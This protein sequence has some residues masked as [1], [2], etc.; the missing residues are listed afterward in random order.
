MTFEEWIKVAPLLSFVTAIA[1]AIT[2]LSVFI[3][4]RRANRRRATLDM[5]MKSLHDT[6]ARNVYAEFKKYIQKDKDD[7]DTFKLRSLADQSSPLVTERSAVIAQINIYEL[8]A[9]GINRGVFDEHFY[10][11][12]FHG[13]FTKDYTSALPML[14]A[15]WEKRPSVYCEYQALYLRWMK[16]KHPVAHPS[17]AKMGWWTLTGQDA[18]VDAARASIGAT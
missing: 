1:S 10:K 12:W 2:A 16:K 8:I 13:Q 5:V 14:E 7:N 3:Y 15:I 11:R 6:D 4:T 18:R 17:R 9:L